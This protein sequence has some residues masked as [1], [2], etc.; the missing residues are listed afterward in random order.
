MDEAIKAV[1]GETL[2][3]RHSWLAG[4]LIELSWGQETGYVPRGGLGHKSVQARGGRGRPDPTR[5]PRVSAPALVVGPDPAPGPLQHV[6]SSRAPRM[7]GEGD[8]L[9]HNIGDAGRSLRPCV[10]PTALLP[11]SRVFISVSVLLT[12]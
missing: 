4:H 9:I 6:P 5:T 8:Q 7:P 2:P 11:A 12:I 1:P 3:E 10:G